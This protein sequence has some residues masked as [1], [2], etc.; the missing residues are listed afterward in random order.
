VLRVHPSV[1]AVDAEAVRAALLQELARGGMVDEYQARL[2]ERAWSLVVRR[3]PPVVT[4][5][6]KVLPFHL[7]RVSSARASAG[8]R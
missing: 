8:A 7:A 6:G 4:P 1:G 5:A 3:L 2:I